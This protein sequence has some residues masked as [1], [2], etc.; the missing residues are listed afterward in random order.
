MTDRHRN[1]RARRRLLSATSGMLAFAALALLLTV[2]A[3]QPSSAESAHYK[4]SWVKVGKPFRLAVQGNTTYI[5]GS[6]GIFGQVAPT[7]GRSAGRHPK[8]GDLHKGL[9]PRGSFSVKQETTRQKKTRQTRSKQ[10]PENA[11]TLYFEAGGH[12][13]QGLP[14]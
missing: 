13:E 2:T 14:P 11:M 4:C 8:G 10:Q 12:K 5:T 3:A 6:L 1:G 7:Q 9:E